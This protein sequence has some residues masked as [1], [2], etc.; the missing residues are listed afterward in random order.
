[1]NTEN[2]LVELRPQKGS[3]TDFFRSGEYQRRQKHRL[4]QNATKN[5]VFKSFFQYQPLSK[6]FWFDDLLED[7]K[8]LTKMYDL[9]DKHQIVRDNQND[10]FDDYDFNDEEWEL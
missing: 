2:S 1:M 3:I 4:E 6:E 8:I 5:R 10:Y 7:K 9:F